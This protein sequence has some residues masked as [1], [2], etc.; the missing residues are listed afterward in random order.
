MQTRHHLPVISIRLMGAHETR[1]L[2][3]A[4]AIHVLIPGLLVV[5]RD[6]IAA[7]QM[8]TV[9]RRAARQADAVFNGQ[10]ATPYEVPGWGQGTQVVHS[11]VSLTGMFSGV[12]IY[13]RTPQHSPSRCGEL[14]VQVGALRIVCD[15]RAAFD[16]QADT[17]AQAAALV[18][19][20]WR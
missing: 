10:T 18:P 12:Q 20:V 17:W 16:R 3:E 6:R 7:W 5:L 4:D 8:A 11:A 15:D 13:G 19:E 2:A 9:W 14:K 1:V